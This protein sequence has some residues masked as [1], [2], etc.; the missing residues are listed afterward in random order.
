MTPQKNTAAALEAPYPLG[1]AGNAKRAGWNAFF[2]G[3]ARDACPFPG[4]RRDLRLGYR[5]GW[6][7]AQA[8]SLQD[9]ATPDDGPLGPHAA[10][11]L[12][13]QTPSPGWREAAARIID[14]KAYDSGEQIDHRWQR[15]QEALAKADQIASLHAPGGWREIE[16]AKPDPIYDALWELC[17][18]LANEGSPKTPRA[19]AA[20]E[21]GRKAC[22]ERYNADRIALQ[23]PAPVDVR[24][25]GDEGS[26]RYQPSGV[27]PSACAGPDNQH[28]DGEG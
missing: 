18:A 5:E 26:S 19:A 23:G 28:S 4:D 9:G 12:G 2:A 25:A 24:L 10:G 6:D 16:S 8:R 13:Q 1:V 22:L 15:K 7:D 27:G 11:S 20:W 21:A 3:K 17:S 14:R